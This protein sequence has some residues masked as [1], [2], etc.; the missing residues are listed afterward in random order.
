MK[1]AFTLIELVFAIVIIGIAVVAMPLLLLQSQRGN[2]FSLQQEAINTAQTK[3]ATIAGSLWDQHV[4][5]NAQEASIR[6]GTL[7]EPNEYILNTRNTSADNEFNLI[8]DF[9]AT[10][11]IDQ[12]RG[13]VLGHGR[14]IHPEA[15]TPRASTAFGSALIVANQYWAIEDYHGDTDNISVTA[16]NADMVL[17]FNVSTNVRYVSDS[18]NYATR[19]VNFNLGTVSTTGTTNIKLV[20][21]GARNAITDS[22]SDSI[23]LVLRYYSFNI[24]KANYQSRAY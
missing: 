5:T 9:N 4:M 22:A 14:G 2:I 17:D 18:T 12:R 19:N 10:L 20:E 11:S 1:K 24:G 7:V 23:N 15:R 16:D 13:F 8:S 6:A 21:V 3:I